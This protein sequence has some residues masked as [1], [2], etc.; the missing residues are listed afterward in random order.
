MRRVAT[1]IASII[2]AL[3]TIGFMGSPV[4][5]DVPIS[6]S[7][8]SGPPGTSVTISGSGFTANEINI[9]V[10]YDSTTVASGITAGPTGAWSAN[11]V[12]PASASGNHTIDAL[13]AIQSANVTEVS[14][15]VTPAIT[16]NPANGPPGTSITVTGSGFGAS[17]SGLAV[18]LDGNPVTLSPAAP[19]ASEK[20]AWSASFVMPASAAGSRTIGASGV[21][22]STASVPGVTFAV[23]PAITLNPAS[24]PPGT[25]ITVTG[26][27]F[28]NGES[29]LTVTYDSTKVPT[30]PPTV[31]AN[32]Q[33]GWSASIVVPASAGGSHP[34]DASGA[35]SAATSVPDTIFTITPVISVGRT[36]AP[37]G[38]SVPIT[39]AGFAANESGITITCDGTPA[40]SGIAA[41]AQGAW[42]SSFVVP[43]LAAGN[44]VIDAN[45]ATST[46]ATVP[47]ISFNITAAIS[48]SR[49]SG[50]A[51]TSITVTG[52]GFSAGETGITVTYDDAT[53]ATGISANPQGAWKATFVV[54][55]SASGSHTINASG[56]VTKAVSVGEASLNVTA[57]ITTSPVSGYVG[58]AV[59]VT[60]S[61]FAA[62]NN[63]RFTYDNTDISVEGATT[64]TSGSFTKSVTVPKSKAGAHT[65][66][67]VDAERNEAKAT[68]TMENAPPPAP[69]ILS[70]Q[71]GTRVGIAGGAT[72]TFK[73]SPATDPSG[74]TYVLQIDTGPDFTQPILERADI[75]RSSYT[76]TK[77][78][79][80][81]RGQYFWRVKAVD[82]ASNQSDWS[83]EWSIQSGMMPVAAF[84]F[85]IILGVA[86]VG[87]AVYFL[88]IRGLMRRREAAVVEAMPEE[89][90]PQVFLG[91]WREVET[92][93][94]RLRNMPRRKALAQPTRTKT[95]SAEDMAR[96]KVVANFAQSLPLMEA[97]YDTEWITNLVRGATGTELSPQT[98]EQLLKGELPVRYEPAWTRHPLYLE[99]KTLLEGQPV[100]L[101]LNGFVDTAGHC[102]SEA[103]LLLQE[104]YRDIGTEPAFD[105]TTKGGWAFIAGVYTDALSWFRGKSLLEPSERDYSIKPSDAPD[106]ET[107]VLCLY[108]EESTCFS[109][110][111]IQVLDEKEALQLRA[112][113]LK[114]RRTYRNSDRARQLVAMMTQ[115]EVQRSRLLSAFSQFGSAMGSS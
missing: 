36:S 16:I 13:S 111:L 69:R 114:L 40:A 66:K 102:T 17:E 50:A 98:Y 110:P 115:L 10:T 75:A 62:N 68:F 104:V 27:G 31:S 43:A 58:L 42:S 100:L 107:E 103:V 83:P 94:P 99:L 38:A 90:T 22:S 105:L 67:V 76:L 55:P 84:I 1:V 8:T 109:G 6:L 37:V 106:E 89:V 63:L 26:S 77:A 39:G 113:H 112:L 95:L 65:I 20:G 14:F 78:E 29:G 64:D 19:S 82:G 41:N 35:T 12:V 92:E 46:A 51:G 91:Q 44:H 70:P 56:S 5:A 81:T 71:D 49:A 73:W 25:S 93:N 30:V 79:A 108:G 96:L 85:I 57:A 15:Y 2:L 52:S 4:L 3:V 80:L 97:C 7:R 101:E 86:L 9:T 61:G 72:P 18:T 45:G 33:G 48:I 53:V 59:E 47:D 60:G 34:I 24:G 23:N 74:V 11:F 32:P 21:S 54:P 28:S 87:F 88:L